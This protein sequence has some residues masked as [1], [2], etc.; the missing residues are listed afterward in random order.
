MILSVKD[1][2]DWMI[3]D[4]DLVATSSKLVSTPVL[5]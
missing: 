1:T 2:L 5:R 3:A 4:D